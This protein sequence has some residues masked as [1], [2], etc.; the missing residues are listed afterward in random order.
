MV[1]LIKKKNRTSAEHEPSP[2][3]NL[4]HK[5]RKEELV[6]VMKMR[7]KTVNQALYSCV[8]NCINMEFDKK[9]KG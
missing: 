6:F 8:L 1:C 2:I 7:N 4:H 3:I 5:L 9:E